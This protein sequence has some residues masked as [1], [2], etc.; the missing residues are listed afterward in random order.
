MHMAGYTIRYTWRNTDTGENRDRIV[1]TFAVDSATQPDAA[2]AIGVLVGTMT[3]VPSALNL[4]DPDFTTDLCQV[5]DIGFGGP[6]VS[7]A[8]FG[9]DEMT[10]GGLTG[11]KEMQIVISRWVLDGLGR[12]FKKG[13]MY[14]GPLSG[15]ATSGLRRPSAAQ[16][17]TC[18]DFAESL[19]NGFVFEGW[20]P[21]VDSEAGLHV[22]L[23]ITQYSVDDAF[24]VQRRRG[25]DPTSQVIRVI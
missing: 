24:D 5:Y 4:L 10:S 25:I 15:S 14:Y 7:E 9:V 2:D 18:L 11:P 13:R 21:V 16:T 17:T 12:P 6:P 8:L 20:T 3:A 19:H 1:W 23:P 22:L